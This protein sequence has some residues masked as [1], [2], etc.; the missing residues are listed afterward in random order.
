MHFTCGLR[1]NIWSAWL[2]ISTKVAPVTSGKSYNIYVIKE[3]LHSNEMWRC[4]PVQVFACLVLAII[5]RDA[6]NTVN[7]NQI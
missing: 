7:K 6:S 4:K 3:V 5:T 1:A 2:T